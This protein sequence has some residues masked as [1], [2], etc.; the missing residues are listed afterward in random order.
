MLGKIESGRRGGR[1]RM[2][3][4]DGVSDSMDMS[5]G[6]LQEL[7]ID[8]EAWHAAVHG[9]AKSRTRLSDWIEAFLNLKVPFISWPPQVLSHLFPLHSMTSQPL[10]TRHPAQTVLAEVTHHLFNAESRREAFHSLSCL[11]SQQ[12]WPSQ[13]LPW[14][15]MVPAFLLALWLLPPRSYFSWPFFLCPSRKHLCF[16]ELSSALFFYAFLSGFLAASVVKNLPASAREAEDVSSVPQLKDSPIEANG[17]PLQYSCRNNPVD[18]G[19]WQATVPEVTKSW[20]HEWACM[21]T[22]C[23]V[24]SLVSVTTSTLHAWESPRRLVKCKILGSTPSVSDSIGLE[25]SPRIY[26]PDMFRGGS[27]GCC[28]EHHALRFAV[29]VKLP[30]DN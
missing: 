7:V 6:R 17:S 19:A 26:L 18:R 22:C 1:Q 11:T 30:F 28:S 4:L 23:L 25:W 3:W 9:V 24:C 29:L 13:C 21:H 10:S 14:A 8:R 15:A 20:P 12:T 2:R 16:Q 5:L 27:W